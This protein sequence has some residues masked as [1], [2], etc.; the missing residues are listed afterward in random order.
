M[1]QVVINLELT[2]RC[3]Y[4]C[5]V[6]PQGNRKNG[7]VK[8]DMSLQNFDIF[9]DRVKE[10]FKKEIIIREIINSGYGE[11]FLHNNLEHILARYVSLKKELDKKYGEYPDISL[12]TNGSV[13]TEKTLN[14]VTKAIDI[15][16]FSFPS[17][18]PEHYGEIMY[19]DKRKG[20]KLF[21]KA[22]ENLLKCMWAY[23]DKR[24]KRTLKN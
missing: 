20:K 22:K 16:K 5:V 2:S 7:I 11:T 18:D 13:I 24:L 23:R 12:V 14:L 10:A 8:K 1:K 6:C 15:L 4:R 9:L 19:R 3:N 21:D 17:S